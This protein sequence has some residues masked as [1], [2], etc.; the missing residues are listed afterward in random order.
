MHRAERDGHKIGW[1]CGPGAGQ[2]IMHAH[3]HLMPRFKDEPYA[4]RG[5]R[6]W[7]KQEANGRNPDL[8]ANPLCA[9]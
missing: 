2:E 3:M 5:I 6:F 9:T 7:L 4:G 1:N 8:A